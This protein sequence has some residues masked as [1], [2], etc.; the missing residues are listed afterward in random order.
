MKL[1]FI[2]HQFVIY[3]DDEYGAPFY[4]WLSLNKR[5]L[6]PHDTLVFTPIPPPGES[7]D[8][9]RYPFKN[10]GA[11]ENVLEKRR[12]RTFRKNAG[13]FW[14]RLWIHQRI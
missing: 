3:D 2:F 6:F 4:G 11:T 13:N 7:P 5:P 8:W 14:R 10:L 1:K 12:K 9:K